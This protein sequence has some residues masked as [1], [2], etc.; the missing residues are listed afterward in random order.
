MIPGILVMMAAALPPNPQ[1][2]SGKIAW[3]SLARTY[4]IRAMPKQILAAL[5]R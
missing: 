1:R 4:K 2:E 3:R 5:P